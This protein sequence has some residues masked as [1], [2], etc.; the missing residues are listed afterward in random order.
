MSRKKVWKSQVQPCVPSRV[1][2]SHLESQ[3]VCQRIA[4]ILVDPCNDPSFL[5]FGEECGLVREVDNEDEC[6][7]G[8]AQ[9]AAV[10]TSA[11]VVGCSSAASLHDTKE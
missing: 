6:K 3:L 1:Q 7:A 10:A 4:T 11:D 9:S 2:S 5:I 8:E